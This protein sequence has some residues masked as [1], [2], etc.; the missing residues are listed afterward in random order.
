VTS[1]KLES[2]AK[3]TK[4]PNPTPQTKKNPSQDKEQHGKNSNCTSVQQT[5]E[6]TQQQLI[7]TPES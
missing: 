1:I 2:L 6:I 5:C 3:K 4:M 7:E